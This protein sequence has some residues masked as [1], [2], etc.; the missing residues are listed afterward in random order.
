MQHEAH[1]ALDLLELVGAQEQVRIV[2]GEPPDAHQ[3]VQR[4]GALVAVDG[5]QLGPAERQLAVADRR[6]LL[7]I[8]MWNGQFIGLSR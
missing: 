8:W 3:P 4:A 1:A 2:L 6:L 7:K 5:A